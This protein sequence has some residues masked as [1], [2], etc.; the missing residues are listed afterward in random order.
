MKNSYILLRD[1][2]E[3]NALSIEELQEIGLKETDLIWI[4]CQ[5]MDWRSPLEIAELKSLITANNYS[6][7]NKKAEEPVA[8][9]EPNGKILQ[10]KKKIISQIADPGVKDPEKYNRPEPAIL[11]A[12]EKKEIHRQSNVNAAPE[13]IKEQYRR[14][15]GKNGQGTKAVFTKHLPDQVKKWALYAGLV[16]TGAFLM[17]L[18]LNFGS[19]RK[20]V[21][22]QKTPPAPKNAASTVTTSTLPDTNLT[23]PPA[24][25][26]TPELLT[27]N[28]LT[29]EKKVQKKPVKGT[30]IIPPVS[31]ANFDSANIT[32]ND[33]ENVSPVVKVRM[34]PVSIEDISSKINLSAN[35]YDVGFLGGIKNLAITLQN[36][37]DYLLNKVTV[38]IDYLNSAGDIVNRDHVNF[39]SVK[40][41]DAPVMQVDKSK[42]G[43][44]VQY[45]ITHIEC[46]A[47]TQN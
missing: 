19:N 45:H 22:E 11:P 17:F 4:E 13:V 41:G 25:L 1:N 43:V 5:S 12:F 15:P 44:K 42:R 34:R 26:E 28:S 16:L 3:S 8:K 18:I 20:A 21:V 6:N 33:T 24:N 37:S 32:R 29:T 9:E 23:I 30:N 14:Y 39:Q 40:A 38:E 35:D 47:V 27:K 46:N 10:E 31:A 2:K 36:N 7:K